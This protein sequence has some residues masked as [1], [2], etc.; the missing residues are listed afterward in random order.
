MAFASSQ[1]LTSYAAFLLCSA[2]RRGGMKI[3]VLDH[4]QV[5]PFLLLVML[6]MESM[7]RNRK[8]V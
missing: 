6:V 2:F 8:K 5:L 4:H 3:L 1:P 7:H